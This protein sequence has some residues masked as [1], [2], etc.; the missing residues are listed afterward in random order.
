MKISVIIPAYN[1]EKYIEKCLESL[2]KQTLKNFEIIVIDDGS[3][4]NTKEVVEQYIEKNKEIKIS[5]YS[6]ENGGLASARNYGVKYA[7]GEYI[8]FLDA[9]DYLEEDLFEKLNKYMEENIDLIKFKMKRVNEKGKCIEK[10]DGPT[11]ENKTGEEAYE[12][13]CTN[14]LY[15]DPACIYLYRKEFFVKEQFQ[16]RLRYHEDFGLTSLIIIKAKTVASTN[17]YGY[18]YV[19]TSE[20]LTRSEN[21]KKEL[22]RAKDLLKHYDYMDGKIESY[23]VSKRTK[24]LVKRYYTNSLILKTQNLDRDSQKEYIKEIKKRKIYKN[25]KPCNLKQCLKRILLNI[26]IKLYLKMR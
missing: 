16:Y 1:V 17:I 8:S 22:I 9:D 24:E 5:C 2:K 19:Q 13:L 3:K 11:F 15:M 25:I 14:D 12:L 7:K 4:D 26:D 10:I 6:K 20:S 21:P 18:N 23:Q